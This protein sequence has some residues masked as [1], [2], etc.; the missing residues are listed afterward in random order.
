[1]DANR[2]ATRRAPVSPGDATAAASPGP[3]APTP[4]SPAPDGPVSAPGRHSPDP[5][6]GRALGAEL[7]RIHD[8]LRGE[9][10]A[11]RTEVDALLSGQAPGTAA[12]RAPDLLLRLR[13]HC[14]TFCA[15]MHHH[16]SRESDTFPILE[17]RFPDLAPALER[18]RDEHVAV[19]A[20]VAG[21]EET[22][23]GLR[24]GDDPG[25]VRAELERLSAELEAHF[26]YEEEQIS[27]ALDSPLLTLPGPGPGALRP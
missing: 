19:A 12:G 17:A 26:A 2:R 27:P 22:V 23:T 7:A 15:S 21:L 6:R 3:D 24:A 1:M 14:L 8:G 18:L 16:H 20:I 11:V 9:L 5:A 4:A 25:P 13:T 10:A